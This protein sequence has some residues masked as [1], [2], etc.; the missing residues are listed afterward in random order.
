[1]GSSSVGHCQIVVTFIVALNLHSAMWLLFVYNFSVL[2]KRTH[3][4]E[5]FKIQILKSLE[6]A[7]LIS[8]FWTESCIKFPY[9]S[10]LLLTAVNHT[11]THMPTTYLVCWENFMKYC[12]VHMYI[13]AFP[14][15]KGVVKKSWK[16]KMVWMH[17]SLKSGR[18]K[19]VRK[20][21]AASWKMSIPSFLNKNLG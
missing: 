3:N 1:M 21:N 9:Y 4:T 16:R 8:A 18:K 2:T 11:R 14:E 20:N 13:P 15:K 5:C 17:F 6:L 19:G 12:F 7:R 10:L